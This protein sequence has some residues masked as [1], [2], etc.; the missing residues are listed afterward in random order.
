MSVKKIAE[1]LE[2][3]AYHRLKWGEEITQGPGTGMHK[4][5]V[6]TYLCQASGRLSGTLSEDRGSLEVSGQSFPLAFTARAQ[7][8]LVDLQEGEHEVIVTV[9]PTW[10]QALDG[11][12]SLPD[13]DITSL[14]VNCVTLIKE[15]TPPPPLPFII[16]GGLVQ[17]VHEHGFEIALS[18]RQSETSPVYVHALGK[19][20]SKVGE[21]FCGLVKLMSLGESQVWML[22]RE[23]SVTW[24][25]F[26]KKKHKKK[27]P[28]ASPPA[29]LLS[30]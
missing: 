10:K 12:P 27:T 25:P 17:S 21:P 1:T 30:S 6:L 14:L 11:E 28:S 29:T 7:K 22:E 2:R 13:F 15:E 18:S 26:K 5:K 20:S 3:R 9:W 19:I 8:H 16:V 4:L 24:E 23:I